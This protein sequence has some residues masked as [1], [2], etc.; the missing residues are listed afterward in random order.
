[1]GHAA[2]AV[3]KFAEKGDGMIP[4]PA[5]QECTNAELKCALEFCEFSMPSIEES[6]W[7]G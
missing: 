7:L 3:R 5:F 1:M 6:R 4:P 2:D